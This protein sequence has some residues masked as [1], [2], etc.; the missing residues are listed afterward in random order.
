MNKYFI[1]DP[2]IINDCYSD[3]IFNHFD[4][5][6]KNKNKDKFILSVSGGSDSVLLLFLFVKYFNGDKSRIIISHIN[7]HLRD[8]S[9][10]DESF[11]TI[12]GKKLNVEVYIKNLNP[13]II[14]NRDS[15]ESWARRG[16]YDS[17][18]N[19]MEK[20]SA[21]WI[22]TGHHANDQAETVLMNI[23]NKTGLFGLGGMK[24]INNKIIRPLLPFSKSYLMK[25]I[26]KYSIPF[27]NDL[28]NNNINYSRNFIRNVVIEPWQKN[29]SELIQAITKTANNF[30]EWQESTIYFIKKF[31]DKNVLKNRYGSFL[32]EKKELKKLPPLAR[33]CV[34]QLLTNSIGQLR[35]YDVENI[36]IFLDKNIV[37]NI[38]K[39]KNDYILLNDRRFIIIKQNQLQEKKYIEITIGEQCNFYDYDYII[40]VYSETFSFSEDPNDEYIDLNKI[41]NKKLILRL[42]KW[43]DRFK[44]L[45]MSGKQKISDFLINNKL[46]YFKKKYQTVLTADDKIIWVC[47]YRIDDS[48]KI[49]SNTK[50]IIR[51]NRKFNKS[52]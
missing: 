11:I 44:P 33:V 10:V 38:Y 30:Q 51:I 12:L 29:D 35:K 7:H 15:I 4:K 21:N 45:G 47:G 36:K 19:I 40:K 18:N 49:N 25:V 27:I 2:H 48:V 17:L 50:N 3:K 28:T 31:I 26:K 8:E 5:V 9:D 6:L 24:E 52:F 34:F 37:G 23:S 20:T 43:G 16:R 13:N 1:P 41:K 14:P 22:V 46:D 42:W 32:I 39:T